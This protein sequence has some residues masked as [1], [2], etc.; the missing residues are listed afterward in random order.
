[1]GAK[2]SQPTN[3]PQS[4]QS[5]SSATLSE[6]EGPGLR[7]KRRRAHNQSVKR[8]NLQLRHSHRFQVWA[9]DQF[10]SGPAPWNHSSSGAGD[11]RLSRRS[12]STKQNETIDPLI[13]VGN[14]TAGCCRGEPMVFA[15][16]V[17]KAGDEQSWRKDLPRTSERP[18]PPLKKGP[19]KPVHNSRTYV[20]YSAIIPVSADLTHTRHRRQ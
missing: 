14:Q 11:H 10:E 5:L 8:A 2:T 18:L 4:A 16:P 9:G 17:P 19:E 3:H 1:V 13:G 7:S 6:G 15:I 20:V 12:I